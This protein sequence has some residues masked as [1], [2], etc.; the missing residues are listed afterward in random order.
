[1][2]C[3]EAV[4][5]RLLIAKI[6][7][8]AVSSDTVARM[9]HV[10]VLRALCEVAAPHESDAFYMQ[11]H[12]RLN[13]VPRG[14]LCLILGDF[15]ARVGS[16]AADCFG[17]HAP[18][19]EN[20]KGER[21]RELLTESNM[22]ALNTF[23]PGDP[24]TW[25]KVAG[26]LARLDFICASA[27]LL[28]DTRWAG[29]RRDIDVW[30]GS[31]E[32]NW[33]VVAEVNLSIGNLGK[34]KRK[35]GNLVRDNWRVSEFRERL[36][37]IVLRDDLDVGPLCT[38]L[39]TD[40]A[41]AART[42]FMKG[43]DEP[44]K[45]WISGD[46]WQLIKWAQILRADLR[47]SRA[48]VSGMRVAVAFNAWKWTVADDGTADEWVCAVRTSWLMVCAQA[49]TAQRQLEVAQARKRHSLKVNRRNQWESIAGDAQ[50]VADCRNMR[51]LYKFARRL[52]AFKPTP[53]PGVKRKDGTLTTDDDEGLARWAEHFATLLGGKQVEKVRA[54]SPAT[55]DDDQAAQLC[56]ILDLTPAN[57]AKML[58]RMP[59]QRAVG[60][61]EI[62]IEIW[63]A[64]GDRLA[65]LLCE[66]MKHVVV[67]GTIPPQ[68]KGG[69]L[70]RLYKGKGDAADCNSHR[71]LLTAD[72]AS[73]VFTSLVWPPIA[74]VCDK[75]L[76][77]EQCGCVRGR[78]TAR[79]MHTSKLFARRVAAHKRPCALVFADLVKAFDRVLRAV[80]MGD[81]SINSEDSSG[82]RVRER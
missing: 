14:Q 6:V 70:A 3:T 75:R 76:P 16:I 13:A 68:W 37:R 7:M 50:R 35:K 45:D 63:I 26:R 4:S 67:S 40:V 27:E 43:K 73:K 29:V 19:T 42:C 9:V 25:T 22:V 49:A 23:F 64:G 79:V 2:K 28:T 59:R 61:D 18:V 74:R 77:T 12:E 11:V 51:E 24:Y 54:P 46:S 30:V 80:V 72:H 62:A 53:V 47:V 65:E 44:R 82:K 60:P 36:E 32:D 78:G 17:T 31:A 55:R 21:M 39:T 58:R 33:P 34:I 10:F 81:S 1:M 56:N 69:R 8:R 20:Q 52:G 41:D 15:N 38:A 57:V 66:L 71:G 5:P 48:N